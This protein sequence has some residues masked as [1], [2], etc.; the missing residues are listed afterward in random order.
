MAR[1]SR[2]ALIVAL[3]LISQAASCPFS[4]TSTT[5]RGELAG[6]SAAQIRERLNAHLQRGEHGEL[7]RRCDEFSLEV[8]CGP[9]AFCWPS[10]RACPAPLCPSPSHPHLW[11]ELAELEVLL[12]KQRGDNPC[13]PN[14]TDG[15]K[16]R[17]ATVDS[18]VAEQRE[19]REYLT[20]NPADASLLERATRDGRCAAA[21]MAWVHH[22]SPEARSRLREEGVRLPLLGD[23]GT[24]EHVPALRKA[25]HN[26]LAEKLPKVITC[27]I[28]HNQPK[29]APSGWT[30]A[31][32]PTWPDEATYN[33]T[34]YG[35]VH[36]ATV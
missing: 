17:H 25:G 16:P 19:E 6:A 14:V 30:P 33:A 23:A 15:R 10:P 36:V 21:A 32:W 2:V 29:A 7:F 26:E 3:Q 4:S 24:A 18:L 13:V 5:V 28:G 1:G 35:S 9:I 31:D 34:G 20:K 27:E 12:H 11:Q 22:L 8:R